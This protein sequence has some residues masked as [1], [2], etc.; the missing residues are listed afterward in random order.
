VVSLYVFGDGYRALKTCHDTYSQQYTL[1]NLSY[2]GLTQVDVRTASSLEDPQ[3]S[4]TGLPKSTMTNSVCLYPRLC[5][6]LFL[7][8][9]TSGKS[10]KGFI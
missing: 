2:L 5:Y 7:A 8:V 10:S 1:D 9:E 6:R 4:I 3:P